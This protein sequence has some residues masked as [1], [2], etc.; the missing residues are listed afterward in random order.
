MAPAL[1]PQ[2]R[3]FHQLGLD[4]FERDRT[5]REAV[6]HVELGDRRGG[7]L[8]RGEATD[9][10]VEQRLEQRL[11]AQQGALASSEDLVLEHLELGS[12]ESLRGFHRLAPQIFPGDGV[13]LRTIHLDEEPLHAI[14]A[15]PETRETVRSR[16]RRSRSIRNCSVLLPSRRSS[17]SSAS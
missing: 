4:T 5:L 17:S 12:D 2:H 11:L 9:Q 10:V 7:R 13:R 8:Q 3:L 6:E 15:Q 14:E 16:S 1:D